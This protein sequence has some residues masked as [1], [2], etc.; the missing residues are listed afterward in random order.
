MSDKLVSDTE[1]LVLTILVMS[2]I[3]AFAIKR[4][5]VSRPEFAIGMPVVVGV[6]LRL[7]AMAGINSTGV[8]SQLRGGDESTFLS[9]AHAIAQTPW[10][11]G[12]LPHGPYQLQTEIFAAQIKLL[13]LSPTALRVTQ[14]GISML[15]IMLIVAAVYDLS[16]PRAARLTAWV[17][18]V[19]PANLFFNSSLSKEPIML[20]ATGLV[21][22]GGTKM[23][24]RI[25]PIGFLLAGLGGL[26]AVETRSYAGW[27]LVSAFVLLI[28]VAAV[29]YMDRPIVAMPVI[30]AVVGI[31]A[32]ATPTLL[33]V[34]SNKS[35]QKLQQSQ[36]FTTGQQA[37]TSSGGSNGDNLALEQVNFSTRGAVIKNLPQRMFDLIFRPYPWQL[38]DTS[39]RLGA[40]GTVIAVAGFFALLGFA[41]RARGDVLRLTAPLLFPFC[42]LLIAYS[43][44]AGNAGTGFRYRS[45][46]VVLG[47][48]MLIILREHVLA[49]RKTARQ[50]EAATSEPVERDVGAAPSPV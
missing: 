34:T 27:F 48:G 6:G 12:F 24:R 43:L 37:T 13:G 17:A 38:H 36:N 45:H 41:W 5:R 44:S 9:Y 30:Y 33:S 35:L 29:R 32:L 28:L 2:G 16:G 11:R 50:S 7:L 8:S 3:L 1:G 25:D 10:G 20:L 49:L 39:Q 15:G 4:M 18:A 19:E 47:A 46:L 42:F 26:I 14:I 31:I 40:V 21:V 23:W 22:L